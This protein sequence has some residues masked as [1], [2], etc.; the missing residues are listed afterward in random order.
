[1]VLDVTMEGGGKDPEQNPLMLAKHIWE[2]I[3]RDDP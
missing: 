1:M 2:V 3:G